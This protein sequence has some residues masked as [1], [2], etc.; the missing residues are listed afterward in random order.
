MNVRESEI[1]FEGP[2]L[3]GRSQVRPRDSEVVKVKEAKSDTRVRAQP[4]DQRAE[5]W[6]TSEVEG[7]QS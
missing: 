6:K 1:I 3:G 5:G 2:R 4:R 7:Q